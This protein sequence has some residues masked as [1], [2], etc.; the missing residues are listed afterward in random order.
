MTTLRHSGFQVSVVSSLVGVHSRTSGSLCNFSDCS[1]LLRFLGAL[2][3]LGIGFATQLQILAIH[4]WGGSRINSCPS[5]GLLILRHLRA[6]CCTTRTWRNRRRLLTSRSGNSQSLQCV[7]SCLAGRGC[8]FFVVF[9]KPYK[10]SKHHQ[11]L[12]QIPLL[13][14]GLVHVGSGIWGVELRARCRQGKS[15]WSRVSG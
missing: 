1:D 6:R 2:L 3:L 15:L 8:L 14:P 13:G 11:A 10:L 5:L 12:S 4:P 9:P 7:R